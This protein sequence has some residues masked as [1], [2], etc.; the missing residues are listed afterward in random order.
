M[1]SPVKLVGK[2]RAWF[3][4]SSGHSDSANRPGY[5]AVSV[6]F[7]LFALAKNAN[8]F[9]HVV[10]FFYFSMQISVCIGQFESMGYGLKNAINF[11]LKLSIRAVLFTILAR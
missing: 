7:T 5:E 4:A 9:I 11:L 2:I 6:Q 8:L 3:Q 1:T 10:C